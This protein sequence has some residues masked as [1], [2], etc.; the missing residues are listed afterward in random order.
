[1]S[2]DIAA[3]LATASQTADPAARR[4]LVAEARVRLAQEAARL[5]ALGDQL[6]A[7]ERQLADAG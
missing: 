1:M 3:M 5:R 4:A 7:F 2:D 6:E